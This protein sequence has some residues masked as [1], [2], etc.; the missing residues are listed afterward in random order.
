MKLYVGNI[1]YKVDSD[2]LKAL[3][4]RFGEVVDATIILDRETGKSKGFGFV[5]MKNTEDGHKA[6]KGLDGENFNQRTLVVEEATGK[7]NRRR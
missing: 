2:V 1:N 3:F 4:A 5:T 7:P 6:I